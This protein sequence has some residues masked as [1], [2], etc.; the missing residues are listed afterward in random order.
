M[1][2]FSPIANPDFLS[3]VEIQELQLELLRKQLSYAREHSPYYRSKLADWN[4]EELRNLKDLAKLPLTSKE[5]LAN[6]NSDFL[7]IEAKSIAEFV[8][9]S[10]STGQPVKIALS[11]NDLHRLA[12]NEA[13]SLAIAGFVEEDVVQILT[14]LDKCFMAGMAYYSGLQ[15]LG[16][17]AI[18]VG[19]G[20]PEFHWEMI[21]QMNPS[22][23]IVVP[24]YLAKLCSSPSKIATPSLKKALCIGEPLRNGDFSDN[25]LAINI[26]QH[27][28]L[29]LR[30]T[31]A[32][33]EMA[34]AFTECEVK[35]GGHHIPELIV[36]ELLDENGNEVPDGQLGEVTVTPLGVEAM[37]LIRFRTGDLARRHSERCSCGRNTMRLG[38]IEGR[39]SQMVKL[40]GTTIFPPQIQEILHRFPSAQPYVIEIG[41][42]ENKMDKIHI[43][44]PEDGYSE[45]GQIKKALQAGLRVS[46]EIQIV[47]TAEIL[48]MQTLGDS[49]K[50]R[51]IIDT[52]DA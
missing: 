9:T 45:I 10:G 18:R 36:I 12:Y 7:A 6:N 37:P 13:R 42:D 31:Y 27:W 20:T 25:Q 51:K 4:P 29:D 50:P 46:P 21:S 41:R 23:L 30:S 2:K 52:R 33:T 1:M 38:P 35:Q 5:D 49:R 8:T 16:A 24:S 3:E 40:K 15:E 48:R 32:S 19:T 39:L 11:K 47:D 14:T 17:T 34:T 22:A 28:D 26:R 44:L 43:Y